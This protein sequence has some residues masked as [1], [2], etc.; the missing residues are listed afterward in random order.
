[1]YRPLNTLYIEGVYI[2]HG[3]ST[4]VSAQRIEGNC[5]INQQFEIDYTVPGNLIRGDNV[6]VTSGA[7][8]FEKVNIRN[9]SKI[10]GNY[11]AVGT[12]AKIVK[13]DGERF[14]N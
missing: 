14:Y 9:N 12:P 5:S 4:I 10:G 11:I 1:M 8:V 13:K 7:E 6:L 2:Q 3:F